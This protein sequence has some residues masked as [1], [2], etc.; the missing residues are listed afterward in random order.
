M[1]MK[2]NTVLSV[3]AVAGL[4]VGAVACG[5]DSIEDLGV[6]DAR[7]REVADGA[8][9]GVVYATVS[10]PNDEAI[11]IESASASIDARVE[12]HNVE[13]TDEGTMSMFEVEEGFSVPAG[14]EFVFEP[15]GPHIMLL[16]VDSATFPDD[17]FEV[18]LT[19][20][21]GDPIT[22]IAP[23]EAIGDDAMSDMDEMDHSDDEMDHS[24]GDMEME[25]DDDG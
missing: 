21:E 23:V 22:F 18:T 6:S 25:M 2:R 9:T 15:G 13:M 1:T 19:L 8:T 14:G 4:S 20:S 5:D 10:N 7:S 3:V 16:D 12:L 24:D 17:E 11:Q